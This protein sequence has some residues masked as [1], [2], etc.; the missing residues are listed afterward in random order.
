MINKRINKE[1]LKKRS[2]H[3]S[4]ITMMSAATSHP[5]IWDTAKIL[6]YWWCVAFGEALT[7]D[8]LNKRTIDT[9]R[10]SLLIKGGVNNPILK[11]D[12]RIYRI[13]EFLNF[14][15]EFNG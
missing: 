2:L 4:F 7:E 8:D 5:A 6:N 3:E 10:K 9:L 15:E 14:K 12:A 13:K 1:S 11:N